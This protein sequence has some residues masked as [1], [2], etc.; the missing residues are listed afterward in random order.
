[1]VP[2][3]FFPV[4][5]N[6]LQEKAVEATKQEKTFFPVHAR[7]VLPVIQYVLSDVSITLFEAGITF[8]LFEAAATLVTC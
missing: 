7:V 6:F 4:N 2:F 3:T 5:V 1:L 8:T